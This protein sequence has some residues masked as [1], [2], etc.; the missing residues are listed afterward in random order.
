MR[1]TLPWPSIPWPSVVGC[2][3][4]SGTGAAA[5]TGPAAQVVT[6]DEGTFQISVDGRPVGTETF[7]IRQSGVGIDGQV[8]AAAQLELVEEGEPLHLRVALD[9]RVGDLSVRR[10][11]VKSSGSVEEDIR[12]EQSGQRFV[13]STSTRG[14]EQEREFRATP[15]TVVLD[16]GVSHQYFFLVSR[17]P[18]GSTVPAVAPRAGRQY[19]LRVTEVGNETLL[20]GGQQLAA[21]H[22]SAEGGGETRDLWVDQEGRVLQ[23]RVVQSRYLAVREEAP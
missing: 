22:L 17:L 9:A 2:L 23:V 13:S 14:G 18:S 21:R 12:G 11:E 6:L 4:L 16:S 20:I 8:L 15:R 3:F 1:R 10:Y 5:Q 19:D 7:T